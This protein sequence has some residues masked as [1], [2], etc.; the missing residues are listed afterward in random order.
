MSAEEPMTPQAAPTAAPKTDF[1]DPSRMVRRG[2]VILLCAAAAFA[3]A[4]FA[5]LDSAIISHGEIVVHTH[6]KAIQHVDGGTVSQVL[7]HDGQ[8][9]QAGQVLVLLD[10]VVAKANVSLLQS[11]ADALEAQ[12]ARLSAERDGRSSIIFPADLLARRSDPAVAA[13]MAGEETTFR[14]T[15]RLVN[16]QIGVLSQ[17]TEEN[18]R[19]T[20]GLQSQLS[21]TIRQTGLIKRELGSVEELY[22]QGYV[23]ESRLLELRRQAADLEG[24]EGE[25]K[26][27]IAQT[28][29]NS[30]ENRMQGFSLRDQKLNDEVSQLRDVQTKK[31]DTLDRLRAA[32][33]TLA[34]TVI[35][36]PTDGVV[37]G[38]QVHTKGE[39][40]R[41][42]TTVMEL[43][44]QHDEL[45]V[46]V[47]IRPED[48]PQIFKGMTSRISFNSYRQRRLPV[49]TGA[50]QTISADRL[51]D[52]KQ[53]PYFAAI[54]TVDE[55]A[56]KGYPEGRLIPGMPAEVE[57]NTGPRTILSYLTEPISDVMRNGMRE[58]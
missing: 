38:L 25:L 12:E 35:R 1:M 14:S 41:P 39:V 9:V 18:A 26:G 4:A 50:V 32:Q 55:A 37:V 2:S 34:N 20:D 48:A 33:Q 47:H 19:I 24:Q 30:G 11:Q 22:A 46:S 28:E 54:V 45:E 13:A 58:R 40:I 5:P 36:A 15:A 56:L 27:K 23:P 17:R 44:P 21:A 10:D 49:L 7:A 16:Q 53:Q 8:S 43:V 29:A 6:R 31:F 51:L 3:L 57:I 52:D 42:G